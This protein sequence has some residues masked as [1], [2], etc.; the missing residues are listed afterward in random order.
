M[1]IRKDFEDAQKQLNDYLTIAV[2][3]YSPKAEDKSPAKIYENLEPISDKEWGIFKRDIY[4]KGRLSLGYLDKFRN[5][6]L[7]G[8]YPSKEE[9]LETLNRLYENLFKFHKAL[10]NQSDKG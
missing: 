1:S 5:N 10:E 3:V 9:F 2:K 8:L 4:R 7:Q 6:Y